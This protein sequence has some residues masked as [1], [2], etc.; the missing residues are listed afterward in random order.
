[1]ELE[2]KRQK[3]LLRIGEEQNLVI[4]RGQSNVSVWSA[5][6]VAT[7]TSLGRTT[8]PRKAIV[9]VNEKHLFSLALSPARCSS[10]GSSLK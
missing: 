10:V 1:M 9:S 4:T 8:C 6:L 3:T 7:F 2:A 5:V